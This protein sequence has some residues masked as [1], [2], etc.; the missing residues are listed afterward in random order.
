MDEDL[1]AEPPETPSAKA[2][3]DGGLSAAILLMLLAED[4]A[5]A[6]LQQLDPA[7]VKNMG[8]AMFEAASA[9]EMDVER[10]LEN[11][12]ANNRQLSTLA[13]GANGRIRDMMQKAL[14]DSRAGNILSE[15]EPEPQKPSLETL[16][17][18]DVAA[19][20]QLVASEHPQVAAVIL[21]AISPEVAAIAIS[22]LPEQLQ[23]DLLFRSAN[24]NSIPAEAIADLEA[25][26]A[27]RS[28]AALQQAEIKI[29]G[30]D[31][32]GKIVNS[33]SRPMGERLLKSIR[34]KDRVLADTIEEA[35]FVFD[36][37]D[38]LDSKTLGAVLRNVDGDR[39]ALA[40]KGVPENARH[41]FGAC[42]PN[43]GR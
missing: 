12:V 25:I 18:M 42:S 5:A 36:N 33:L 34:K 6:I 29:G 22:G 43:G 31:D 19:I 1:L 39:L 23:A 20:S 3:L 30:G 26:I 24:L 13:V 21:S 11:F 2:P 27:R 40:L 35:M 41:A 38:E 8:K 14:G 16:R 15:I 37:L 32:V 28:G 17:W 9:S 4:E 7:Q 10:A